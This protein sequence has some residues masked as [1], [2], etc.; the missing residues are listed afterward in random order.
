MAQQNVGGLNIPPDFIER[1][2]QAIQDMEVD[3][4]E[5][6]RPSVTKFIE[7]DFKVIIS[8]ASVGCNNETCN[9]NSRFL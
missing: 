6:W 3:G 9:H 8:G 5:L 1:V 7:N 2:Y 4:I